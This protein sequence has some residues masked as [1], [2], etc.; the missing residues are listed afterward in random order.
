MSADVVT[1]LEARVLRGLMVVDNES[2]AEVLTFDATLDYTHESDSTI[3]MHP[4]ERAGSV[5]DH[6]QPGPISLRMTATITNTPYS[7]RP[8]RGRAARALAVLER[9][10]VSKTLVRIS[11][12]LHTY[13]DMALKS[14]SAP[15]KAAT[16]DALQ[17][18]LV[19]QEL[20]TVD[21]V[22]QAV[23]ADLL[24]AQRKPS[25]KDKDP[26]QQETRPADPAQVEKTIAKGGLDYYRSLRTRFTG[27]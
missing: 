16:G 27:R 14:I 2:Q 17:V 7:G 1:V 13:R 26:T 3:S 19:W 5:G 11:T 24:A 6:V 18:A 4:R 21:S 8:D 25:G 12:R 9:V 15:R 22:F 10:R 20:P 23:P